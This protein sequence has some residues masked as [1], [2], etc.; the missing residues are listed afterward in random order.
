LAQGVAGIERPADLHAHIRSQMYDPRYT[1][2][3]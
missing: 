1:E 3:A 2:Y